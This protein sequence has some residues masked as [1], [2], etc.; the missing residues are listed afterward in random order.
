MMPSAVVVIIPIE[1]NRKNHFSAE[2][3]FLVGGSPDGAAAG[4]G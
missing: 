3:D 1:A 4:R 2:D